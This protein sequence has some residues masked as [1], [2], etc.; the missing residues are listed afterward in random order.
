MKPQYII[1]VGT[2]PKIVPL[3]T[4]VVSFEVSIRAP[5]GATIE[6]ALEHPSDSLSDAGRA[7]VGP[8]PT[9]V[10]APNAANANGVLHLTGTP[11]AAVR[12]TPTGN[13]LAT[14]LQQ[15]LR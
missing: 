11:Y 10:A 8:A 6:V 2:T 13:G 1:L 15:G 4:N 3:D 14:I 12:I 9:W 5:A 7:A